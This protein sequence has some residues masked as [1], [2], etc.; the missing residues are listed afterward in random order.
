MTPLQQEVGGPLTRGQQPTLIP[1]FR[2][3]CY[4]KQDTQSMELADDTLAAI[5]LLLSGERLGT[6]LT[7]P[8]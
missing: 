8:N 4:G 3:S 7:L 6:F 1:T 2:E 5:T